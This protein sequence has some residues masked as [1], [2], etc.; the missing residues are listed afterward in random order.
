MS[1]LTY[2]YCLVRSVSRPSLRGVPAGMPGGD[3]VRL[4]EVSGLAAS[5][6]RGT[7]VRHWLVVSTVPEEEYGE[8]ALQRG[9]QDLDWVG[10][11]A[12]A[13]EAVTE[14]FL[15][16]DAVL[17]M[18]LFALFKSDERAVAHV[19][20]HRRRIARILARIQRQLEWGLRLVWA[21]ADADADSGRAQ[22]GTR[23]RRRH[24]MSGA[25]YLARKRDLRDRSHTSQ[26]RARADANR[27]A[28]AMAGKASEARR[29]TDV[30]RAASGSRLLL[31]AAFLVPARRA[32]AFK[33]AVHKQTGA[34][35]Q[36]GITVSL[37]GPWPPYHFI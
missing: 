3:A 24:V 13:H 7:A 21:P 29:K 4:L 8:A 37:T 33:A 16:A 1:A 30:E 18:Q 34:L 31:E 26:R 23:G 6:R 19:T 11:C 14:H 15:T 28:R 35:E 12:L 17:P 5:P 32:G 2:A 20:G 10:P 9:I 36:S 25:D 22:P 27:L